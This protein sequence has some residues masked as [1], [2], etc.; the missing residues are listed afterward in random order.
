MSILRAFTAAF[1]GDV[2]KGPASWFQAAAEQV[3]DTP[4]TAEPRSTA[5]RPYKATSDKLT[6]ASLLEYLETTGDEV[7]V[8]ALR[9]GFPAYSSA[10]ITGLLRRMITNGDIAVKRNAHGQTVY[11]LHWALYPSKPRRAP[12]PAPQP[13]R[14]YPIA[15]AAF[16]VGS[17]VTLENGRRRYVVACTSSVGGRCTYDAVALS[18]GVRGSNPTGMGAEQ[19]HLA[20]NQ[21]VAF[22]GAAV[23]QLQRR[24]RDA[25][26]R[27]GL[28]LDR[29]SE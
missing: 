1:H 25:T 17:V 15:P 19:M 23:G 21:A 28:H 5:P 8:A 6:Q 3:F 10:Q 7:T 14:D 18:G 13:R 9:Y 11:G 4:A 20:R 12:A 26:N 29:C 2:V 22:T 24:Y 16:P 27:C